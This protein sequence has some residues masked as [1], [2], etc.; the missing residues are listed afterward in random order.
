MAKERLAQRI[1]ARVEEDD[2]PYLI[3]GT[4]LEITSRGTFEVK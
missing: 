4:T 2:L 1:Y 3:A